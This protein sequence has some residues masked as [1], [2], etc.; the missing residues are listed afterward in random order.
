MYIASWGG[1]VSICICEQVYH[2]FAFRPCALSK[3][4]MQALE[5][6]SIGL[7]MHN[8]CQDTYRHEVVVNALLLDVTPRLDRMHDCALRTTE[9]P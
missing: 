7:P 4:F 9:I 2:G 8:T 5:P 1:Q 6:R 3:L